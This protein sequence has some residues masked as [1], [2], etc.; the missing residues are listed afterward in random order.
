MIYK[1]QIY[2]YHWQI[3]NKYSQDK[4]RVEEHLDENFKFATRPTNQSEPIFS[5]LAARI[6]I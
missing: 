5:F 1:W 6:F 2:I 4:E 3:H